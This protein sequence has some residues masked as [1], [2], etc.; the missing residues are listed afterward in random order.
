[1]HPVTKRNL[2]ITGA[3]LSAFFATVAFVFIIEWSL[4]EGVLTDGILF[5]WYTEAPMFII[6]IFSLI[7]IPV[8]LLPLLILRE[9]PFEKEER[10]ECEAEK[11]KYTQIYKFKFAVNEQ[12]R[13]VMINDRPYEWSDIQGAEIIENENVVSRT[14]TK[15]TDKTNR[16][17][18]AGK[19]IGGG[20]LFGVGGALIGGSLGGRNSTT[21]SNGTSTTT[22]TNY[23]TILKLRVHVSVS[24]TNPCEYVNFLDWGKVDKSSNGYRERIEMC[25]RCFFIVQHIVNQNI[26]SQ[27]NE[28][29]TQPAI[30]H[31]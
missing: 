31:E 6:F 15:G 17:L 28:T 18:S 30:T 21:T 3:V 13:L 23:C 16:N 7:M 19:A 27:Y 24:I 5:E 4:T 11:A 1:M 9:T 2:K 10:L 12:D 20:L 29:S 26:E 22:E 8:G 14:E 25:E